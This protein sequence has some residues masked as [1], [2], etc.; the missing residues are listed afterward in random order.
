M[1]LELIKNQSVFTTP[2]IKVVG[3]H[4]GGNKAA[5]YV[6]SRCMK[7][8]DFLFTSSPD[9][10]VE[11]IREYE[12]DPVISLSGSSTGALNISHV[13]K[14]ADIVI[15]L[16]AMGDTETDQLIPVITKIR[17]KHK[18]FTVV[19]AIKPFSF[20]DEQRK[21]VAENGLKFL[22][23][24]ADS[25]IVI[26]SDLSLS[27]TASSLSHIDAF[28]T[29]YQCVLNAISVITD[30]L[31]TPGAIN[32]DIQDLQAAMVGVGSVGIGA[33][34]GEGR[35]RTAVKLAL[36]SPQ[37]KHFDLPKATGVFIN[38][39]AGESLTL[40][41]FSEIGKT[42]DNVAS[43][44]STIVMSTTILKNFGDSLKVAV[45]AMN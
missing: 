43:D 18:A 28:N 33:S 39:S 13:V 22:A 42:V 16:C 15:F 44:V 4:K 2:V 3:F 35:A 6:K 23:N 21:S 34:E 45:V 26:D 27:P 9:E 8:I 38:I 7:E 11:A 30:S 37:L 32:V 12:P 10:Y 36:E 31:L 5:K 17:K 41:E 24:C 14:D 1:T 40:N 29:S 25:T 20:E 19:I